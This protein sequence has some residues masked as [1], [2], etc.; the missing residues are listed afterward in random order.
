MQQINIIK[1]ATL[2]LHIP[3]DGWRP[4]V[5]TFVDL[6]VDSAAYEIIVT[7][8]DLKKYRVVEGNTDTFA[9]VQR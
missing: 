5:P 3:V 4:I 6:V 8:N 7:R 2:G 1:T 9:P